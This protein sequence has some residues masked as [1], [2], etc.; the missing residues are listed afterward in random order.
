MTACKREFISLW[1]KSFS[2]GRLSAFVMHSYRGV[3]SREKTLVNKKYLNYKFEN[4]EK[5]KYKN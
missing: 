1:E 3:T 5:I 2:E 4:K